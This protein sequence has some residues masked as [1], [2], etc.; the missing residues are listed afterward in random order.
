MPSSRCCSWFVG[1]EPSDEF[2]LA[3]C[4]AASA[5]GS[6]YSLFRRGCREALVATNVEVTVVAT[7]E[8][9]YPRFRPLEAA[10]S[11]RTPLSPR[12]LG[13]GR[14]RFEVGSDVVPDS[15]DLTVA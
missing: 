13:P 1:C 14:S 11:G 8:L 10:H 6:R 5:S 3:R 4:C 9:S 12:P 7:D 2:D 15:D